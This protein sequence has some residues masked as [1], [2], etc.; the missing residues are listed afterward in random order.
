MG[1]R[2]VNNV[3][4]EKYAARNRGYV[5]RY[6]QSSEFELFRTNS[7]YSANYIAPPVGS[8]RDRDQTPAK[9]PLSF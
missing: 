6:F 2:F 5:V 1:R 3:R 9:E 8:T 7:R 4:L